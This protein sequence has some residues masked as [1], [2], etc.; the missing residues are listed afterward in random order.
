MHIYHT[1]THILYI[2]II[3]GQWL[4]LGSSTR[5]VEYKFYDFRHTHV[6]FALMPGYI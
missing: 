5:E 6:F 2:Y 4:R 3:L 1:N